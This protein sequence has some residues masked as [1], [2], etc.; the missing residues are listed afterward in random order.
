[1]TKMIKNVINSNTVFES[2]NKKWLTSNEA[3]IYLGTTSAGI[4]NQVWRGQ[5]V[6]YKRL[7]RLYFE[8]DDLDRQITFSRKGE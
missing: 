5:L 6:P 4:R 1:M 3:A 7:G 8:R 2:L